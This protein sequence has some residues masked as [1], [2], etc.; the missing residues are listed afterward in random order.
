LWLVGRMGSVKTSTRRRAADR[1]GVAFHDVD[2]EVAAGHGSP[3][4][5]LWDTIGEGVFRELE[6]AV[7]DRMAGAHAVVST[8]GAVLDPA[9]RD[10]MKGT[11]A[12]VWLQA[13]PEVLAA[14]LDDGAARPLL[15]DHPDRRGRIAA[16]LEE[17]GQGYADAADYEIDTSELAV[18]EVAMRIEELWRP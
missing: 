2:E 9:N 14:R 13:G 3:V 5:E 18:E 1:L 7:I 4:P 6:A 8:G 15:E 11:G 17:R 16:L 10:R 12:L